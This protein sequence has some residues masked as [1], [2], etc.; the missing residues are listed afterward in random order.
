MARQLKKG[1]EDR[2][3]LPFQQDDT[4]SF[5]YYEVHRQK[6]RPEPEAKLLLAILED[7][8]MCY[9]RYRFTQAP[10]Q[11]KLFDEARSWIF[12]DNAD[13]PFSFT[14]ICEHLGFSP[15]Y[16]RQGLLQNNPIKDHLRAQ[17]RSTFSRVMTGS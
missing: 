1:L 13:W 4:V 15:Q 2:V 12:E 7:G 17:V 6:L 10:K 3:T 11:K 8:V 5:L 16:I 14:N 9:R